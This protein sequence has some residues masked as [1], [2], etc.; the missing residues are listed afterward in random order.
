MKELEPETMNLV[1]RGTTDTGSWRE[2][3][4][5]DWIWMTWGPAGKEHGLWGFERPDSDSG[6]S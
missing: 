1:G 2:L 6:G 4:R 3:R 5:M